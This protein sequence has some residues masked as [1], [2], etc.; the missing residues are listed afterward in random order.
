MS[1]IRYQITN[2]VIGKPSPKFL[3]SNPGVEYIARGSAIVSN[4][5]ERGRKSVPFS[6]DQVLS[7]DLAAGIQLHDVNG[8]PSV[9]VS[10]A[11]EVSS[12]FTAG[13]FRAV[14]ITTGGVRQLALVRSGDVTNV[15]TIADVKHPLRL[16]DADAV[17]WEGTI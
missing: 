4:D 11:Q 15:R 1:T 3:A 16:T 2:M 13:G 10:V 6:R 5:E 17:L 8:Q 14:V 12:P 9:K 7:L